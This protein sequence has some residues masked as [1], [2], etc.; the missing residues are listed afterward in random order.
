MVLMYRLLNSDELGLKQSYRE[1]GIK[2]LCFLLKK[3]T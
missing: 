1:Q 2:Y 3:Y